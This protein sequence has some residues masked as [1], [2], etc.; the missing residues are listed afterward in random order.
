[1]L[2]KYIRVI[3]PGISMAK[4]ITNRKSKD[5]KGRKSFLNSENILC[6]AGHG[7]TLESMAHLL[8]KK[9]FVEYNIGHWVISQAL[10]QG[11][12]SVVKDLRELCEKYPVV[13]GQQ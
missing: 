5:S 2:L 8:E 4:V 7:L 3:L 11:L 12:G 10:F 13:G 1:M 6:H 9:L